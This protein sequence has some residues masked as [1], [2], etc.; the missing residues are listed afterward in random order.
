MRKRWRR[1][2][3]NKEHRPQKRV[4]SVRA[5]RMWR[6]QLD[7]KLVDCSKLPPLFFDKVLFAKEMTAHM[8]EIRDGTRNKFTVARRHRL[9]KLIA[10][11][12][13]D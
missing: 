6:D 12:F 1:R 8:E 13:D 11:I 10:K 9:D 4:M 7:G 5:I 3:F 2:T